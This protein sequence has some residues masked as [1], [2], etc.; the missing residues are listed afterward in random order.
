MNPS[1]PEKENKLNGS[2]RSVQQVGE[3]VS[4][5]LEKFSHEAGERV[6]KLASSVSEGA[7]EYIESGRSYIRS[8]PIQATAMAAAAGLAAGFLLMMVTRRK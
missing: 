4:G 5:R 3:S 2:S 1:I 6:G 7:T 8:K